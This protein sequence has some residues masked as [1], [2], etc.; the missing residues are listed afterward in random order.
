[1]LPVGVDEDHVRQTVLGRPKIV[2][3]LDGKQPRKV[4]YIPGK[5]FSIVL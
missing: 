1:M 2:D 5:I 4:I 3:L